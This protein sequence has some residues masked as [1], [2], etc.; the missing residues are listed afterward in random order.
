MQ[1][2]LSAGRPWVPRVKR[3]AP[4]ES[5]DLEVS[6][7]LLLRCGQRFALAALEARGA[8]GVLGS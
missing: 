1:P 5:W 4:M 3:V 6:R 8:D 2:A 7:L